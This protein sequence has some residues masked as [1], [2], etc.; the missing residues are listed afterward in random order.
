MIST[1][2]SLPAQLGHLRWRASKCAGLGAIRDFKGQDLAN[3]AWAFATSS[4]PSAVL[5]AVLGTTAERRCWD[6]NEQEAANIAWVIAVAGL[7]CVDLGT[8]VCKS[9]R[10]QLV[11]LCQHSTGI[12]EGYIGWVPVWAFTVNGA[13]PT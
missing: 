6:F 8:L 3:T 5:V 7:R 9:W 10:F 4:F 11:E 12:D 13:A 2:R 1:S